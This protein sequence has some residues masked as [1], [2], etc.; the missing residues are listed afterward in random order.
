MDPNVPWS[1]LVGDVIFVY[2]RSVCLCI[3]PSVLVVLELIEA[4]ALL[5]KDGAWCQG[6]GLAASVE[7]LAQAPLEGRRF[8]KNYFLVKI[9]LKVVF[10]CYSLSEN[11]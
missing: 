4:Q 10:L 11:L 1:Q 8:E 3:C 9:H 7:V 6:S 2:E 5:G